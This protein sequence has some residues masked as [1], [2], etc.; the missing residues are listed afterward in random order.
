MWLA[1]HVGGGQFE[2]RLPR[3]GEGRRANAALSRAR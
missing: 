3:E 2:F 1:G